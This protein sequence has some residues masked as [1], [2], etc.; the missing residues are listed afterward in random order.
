MWQV[1]GAEDAGDIGSEWILVDIWHGIGVAV[2][3]DLVKEAITG[4]GIDDAWTSQR[5]WID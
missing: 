5:T 4:R 2:M 3:A 1:F